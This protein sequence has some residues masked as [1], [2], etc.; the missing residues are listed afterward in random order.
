MPCCH[1]TTRSRAGARSLSRQLAGDPF[2]LI[3]R[4]VVRAVHDQILAACAGAGFAPAVVQE[5]T[6]IHSVAGLVASG[7]GVSIL[8]ASAASLG[9][10]DVVCRP[11]RNNPLSTVMAV[12]T[13]DRPP[14]PRLPCSSHRSSDTGPDDLRGD[15]PLRG[16]ILSAC[17]SAFDESRPGAHPCRV[18]VP[19]PQAQSPTARTTSCISLDGFSLGRS[20]T[21]RCPCRRCAASWGPERSPRR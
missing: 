18:R 10:R 2:V 21:R 17:R 11:L 13:L 12:A 7:L 14:T 8:P 20:P 1:G 16:R 6:H 5:G 3:A 19:R 4:R 9:F 15:R